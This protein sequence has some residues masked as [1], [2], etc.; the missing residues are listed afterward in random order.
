MV[1][2]RIARL[3]DVSGRVALVTGASRGLGRH[4]AL[5]LAAAGADVVAA[6][7]DLERCRDTADAVQ[8]QGRRAL[9]LTLDVTEPSSVRAA[10]EETE[11]ALGPVSVLVNN[12][13]VVVTKA[14]LAQDENDWDRVLDT[15]LKGA[16]LVAQACAQRMVAHGSGGSIINIASLLALRVAKSVPGYAA[17]KAGLVHL[18]RAMAVELAEHDIRVNAI[19]PGYIET[20]MNRDF[21]RSEAG[22]RLI[23]RIPQRRVGQPTDLDGTLLLLASDASA[24]MTGSVLCVDGGHAVSPL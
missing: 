22:Q 5:T 7:R 10:L 13:G 6:A 17:A 20:D 24:H 16:W 4:F 9:A 1:N 3:F 12:A 8:A 2:E 18:T 23:R 11:H 19:A 14:L 21:L 15:N